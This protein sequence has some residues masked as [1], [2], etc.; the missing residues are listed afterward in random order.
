M[1]EHD[2]EK[3]DGV[4]GAVLAGLFLL[5]IASGL[6]GFLFV[7][8]QIATQR[9]AVEA[10]MARE[11]AERTRADEMAARAQAA[12]QLARQAGRS[13]EEAASAAR[14]E[15]GNPGPSASTP[16]PE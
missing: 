14:Q 16:R 7:R 9:L 13:T 3:S 6:G 5:L 4:L 8:W 10:V 2:G 12:E 1:S 15:P 11:A